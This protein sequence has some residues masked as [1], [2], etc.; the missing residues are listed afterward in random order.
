MYQYGD[1]K[2]HEKYRRQIV[3]LAH[4][5]SGIIFM[6]NVYFWYCVYCSFGSLRWLFPVL[7]AALGHFL[8]TWAWHNTQRIREIDEERDSQFP[9]YRRVEAKHWTKW[10]HYPVCWTI[11][12]LKAWFLVVMVP[13]TA[14]LATIVLWRAKSP[15]MGWRKVWSDIN[16]YSCNMFFEFSIGL[17]V[18]KKEI[19]FDYS[20][21]LGEGYREK[22][23]LPKKISTYIGA[24]H[25][26]WVDDT[27][28]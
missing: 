21:W 22:Q 12:P 9:A 17:S 18:T 14:I 19:D 23:V 16:Q 1:L 8:L 5:Y 4:I 28:M 15:F 10:R 11:G 3:F 24:P 27:V 13:G 6:S 2:N 7:N 20:E 25:A 26:S